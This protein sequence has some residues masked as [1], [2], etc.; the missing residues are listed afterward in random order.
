[1]KFGKR[2]LALLLALTM[3]LSNLPIS[4]LAEEITEFSEE[5]IAEVSEM[6]AETTE[7]PTE[8]P[9]EA[10]EETGAVQE[11]SSPEPTAAVEPE[12]EEVFVQDETQAAMEDAYGDGTGFFEVNYLWPEDECIVNRPITI[13]VN[14]LGTIP[15]DLVYVIYPIDWDAGTEP[16][17][18]G[19]VTG[20][21]FVYTPAE[22]GEYVCRLEWNGGNDFDGEITLE[23]LRRESPIDYVYFETREC[24]VGSTNAADFNFK[25]TDVDTTGLKYVFTISMYD[26]DTHEY[27]QIGES[28]VS[29]DPVFSLTPTK[30]GA[31]QV[32]L[33]IRDSEGEVATYTFGCSADSYAIHDFSANPYET[34]I[35]GTV[36]FA[37]DY[38]GVLPEDLTYEIMASRDWD[39]PVASGPVTGDFT[40]EPTAA[41]SFI[42]R[43]Y[44]GDG[45]IQSAYFEVLRR[46]VIIEEMSCDWSN[47]TPIVGEYVPIRVTLNEDADLEGLEYVYSVLQRDTDGYSWTQVGE[48][49]VQTSLGFSFQPEQ[50]DEYQ[51]E[52]VI[53]DKDGDLASDTAWITVREYAVLDVEAEPRNV[54][55]GEPVTITISY[56]GELPQSLTWEMYD[57]SSSSMGVLCKSGTV[58]G[59]SFTLIPEQYGS[60]RVE[61]LD[62][63]DYLSSAFFN[64][65]RRDVFIEVFYEDSDFG[66]IPGDTAV[67]YTKVSGRDA[68]AEGLLFTYTA[69]YRNPLTNKET[70]YDTATLKKPE[71]SFVPDAPGEYTVT[72]EISDEEGILTSDYCS[73]NVFES[74]VTRINGKESYN[75]GD[76]ITFTYEYKGEAF[77][78]KPYYTIYKRGENGIDWDHPVKSGT[79]G[80][81]GITFQAETIGSY[82]I[83]IE[84]ASLDYVITRKGVAIEGFWQYDINATMGKPLTMHLEL[85]D[86]ADLTG[87]Y[88][89]YT[90]YCPENGQW[91]EFDKVEK[92]T[93]QTYTFTPDRTGR[94]QV[95]AEVFD[96]QGLITSHTNN[97]VQV[98]TVWFNEGVGPE[99]NVYNLGET[100]TIDVDFE[101]VDGRPVQSAVYEICTMVYNE[102]RDTYYWGDVIASG[103][104]VN[105]KV[106]YKPTEAGEYGCDI[107]VK[108]QDDVVSTCGFTWRVSA[109]GVSISR[110]ESN[111]PVTLNKPVTVTALLDGTAP[112]GTKYQY[113]LYYSVD[114]NAY[115]KVRTSAASTKNTYTFTPDKEGVWEVVLTLQVDGETIDQ[116]YWQM[117]VSKI[118]VDKI[119]QD[120]AE[121]VLGESIGFKVKF[122]GGTP[123]SAWL[124][125][126]RFDPEG[127]LYESSATVPL[128]ADGTA[129][130][131]ALKPG[132]YIADVNI[133][134]DKGLELF[135]GKSADFT[136]WEE[137][138][139]YAVLESDTY[140]SDPGQPITVRLTGEDI[141]GLASG[142]WQI[143]NVI[144]EDDNMY[145]GEV[146]FEAPY[147]SDTFVF[148]PE[149]GFYGVSLE[150]T[151]KSGTFWRLWGNVFDVDAHDHNAKRTKLEGKEPTDEEPGWK[152]Y[153]VYTCGE[154]GAR[155]TSKG[156]P[157]TPAQIEAEDLELIQKNLI[158]VDA[159]SVVI[160]LNGEPVTTVGHDLSSAQDT[161]VLE[162][163]V[164]PIGARQDLKWKTS[165]D[166]VATVEDG[167]VTIAGPG[168]ATITATAADGSG[169]KATVTF[170][171][172]YRYKGH[173][174]AEPGLTSELLEQ[175]ISEGLQVGDQVYMHVLAEVDGQLVNV[176]AEELTFR[177]ASGEGYA[178]VGED[179]LITALAP[180]N[181]VRIEAALKD[182]PQERTASI[183]ISTT[184]NTPE[185]IALTPHPDSVGYVDDDFFYQ[186]GFVE[187][188]D[189][190]LEL[191]V[192]AGAKKTFVMEAIGL[193]SIIGDMSVK[194]AVKWT[195]SNRSLATV[196]EAK[197]GTVTVTVNKNKEGTCTITGTSKLNEKVAVTL[198]V[199]VTDFAPVLEGKSVTLNTYK[200][201]DSDTLG[202]ICHPDDLI[203]GD[204]EVLVYDKDE[205][206]YVFTDDFEATYADGQVTITAVNEVAKGGKAMLAFATEHDKCALPFTIK[207]SNKLPSVTI[208]QTRK[209]NLKDENSYGLL[210]VTAK[211][212]EV[213]DI[214]LED[215]SFNLVLD[216]QGNAV[217]AEDGSFLIEHDGTD[218]AVVKTNVTVTLEGYDRAYTKKNLKIAKE[219]KA[220]KPILGETTLTLF[221]ELPGMTA[222][223]TLSTYYVGVDVDDFELTS[224]GLT[225]VCEDGVLTVSGTP[226]KKTT[227]IKLNPEV[228]GEPVQKKAITL[229]VKLADAPKVKLKPTTAKLK[230]SEKTL[231][232]AVTA[233]EAGGYPLSFQIASHED[234]DAVYNAETGN[235]ELT[236]KDTCTTTGRKDPIE[237]IPMYGDVALDKITLKVTVSK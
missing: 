39:N 237:L 17:A 99:K 193:H 131:T 44:V 54:M 214:E 210:K 185:S 5:P 112:K 49:S 120:K 69:S 136:V 134:T 217:R 28:I 179:G 182:D 72:L 207:V 96:A 34:P 226:A 47:G 24:L 122:T 86:G 82:L 20:K 94:W 111:G 93:S 127:N 117:P 150:V 104:V 61:L 133:R 78:E 205:K 1:M 172:Y 103:D 155:V 114:G 158:Y 113:T 2:I 106:T 74:V 41:G 85:L 171:V 152:D 88:Y 4:V 76:T 116:N 68:Q 195:T 197:D 218:E 190:G 22:V 225:V 187:G 36:T 23:V 144:T 145:W 201:G 234:V 25:S 203:D 63:G 143:W 175:P 59:S 30:A 163:A 46:N 200:N 177:V 162:A 70:V 220:N 73:V 27:V 7:A 33:V 29:A 222:S 102:E 87:V 35:G 71:Y 156:V 126:Y 15:A 124:E 62:G 157:M 9:E 188:E 31:Y 221:Q 97:W 209:V 43:L 110:L 181:R 50:A 48:S 65:S 95:K 81:E 67:M 165:D 125:L 189:G 118:T 123:E 121:T 216:E 16:L 213:K 147:E 170:E 183:T 160:T 3:L 40:W 194:G 176:P 37:L 84:Q 115:E 184:P 109:Y 196:K 6:Q 137:N 92:T 215:G 169:T 168:K 128:A 236:L 178:I 186:D 153:Y 192:Y 180:R 57:T 129:T 75:V 198:D 18:T 173:L 12:T 231:T 10:P 146:L 83:E 107:I 235:L 138:F 105:G 229:K 51:V 89:A 224:G 55:M 130:V 11:T 79:I 14:Y 191:K 52:L 202:L 233:P 91:Q 208:K 90:A 227:S 230:L 164:Q 42:C 174:G 151:T 139:A 98:G 66:L 80:Q 154:C 56:K 161:Y 232:V 58:T 212:A 166:D 140:V 199:T 148:T 142:T 141:S 149:A 223:T 132:S 100:V 8:A 206:N 13:N 77:E 219:E 53:R 64:V 101:T 211:N 26:E 32:E 60:F 19:P 119:E 108:D 135:A 204:P 45:Q 38:E 228:D 159:Q 21:T 167:V